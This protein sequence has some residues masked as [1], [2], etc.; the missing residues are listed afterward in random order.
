MGANGVH[1]VVGMLPPAGGG[2]REGY[3]STEQV[4]VT[5]ETGGRGVQCSGSTG[6]YRSGG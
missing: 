2:R 1:L 5:V 3:T 4:S 6:L